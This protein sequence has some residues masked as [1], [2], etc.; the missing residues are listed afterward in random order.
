[1]KKMGMKK[2]MKKQSKSD[3][4]DESLSMKH[5]KESGMIESFKSRR[6]ESKGMMKKGC[7][8]GK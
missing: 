7:C 8:R 3:R 5:G 6:A 2:K 4:M 1:M